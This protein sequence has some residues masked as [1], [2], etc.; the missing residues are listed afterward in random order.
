MSGADASPTLALSSSVDLNWRVDGNGPVVWLLL[1][2]AGLPLEFWDD[3]AQALSAQHTVV[4]MDQRNAGKTRASGSF[5]LTDV[6]AD[7]AALLDHLKVERVIVAGHAW[8][9]RVAQVF[10]RDHPHRV[11]GLVI[12]GTGGQFPASTS[13][14]ALTSLREAGRSSDRIRWEAALEEAWCASGFSA[15]DPQAF[16][17]LS[18][19]MWHQAQAPAR[20][21]RAKWDS[22][23]AP[24]ASYWGCARV[25]ACLIYGTE[26]SQGTPRNAEDL[27]SRIPGAQLHFIEQAGHFIIREQ[28]AAV[29]ALMQDFA[30]SLDQETA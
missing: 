24:S 29:I 13:A 15:R 22:R 11:V 14:A 2:G 28:A 5:S 21:S 17:S 27:A 25:P 6:A 1:N 30:R 26:D 18:A 19:L 20:P 8:G 10:A 9:G 4:R 23:V 3:I 7:A 12:C 16:Q